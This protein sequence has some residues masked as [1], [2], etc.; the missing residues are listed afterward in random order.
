M[1][2]KSHFEMETTNKVSRLYGTEKL[3][4]PRHSHSPVARNSLR[5]RL[6]L[7]EIQHER[8]LKGSSARYIQI[9][10]SMPSTTFKSSSRYLASMLWKT[11]SHVWKVFRWVPPDEKS[12]HGE[13]KDG[14]EYEESISIRLANLI[15]FLVYL[16]PF[17]CA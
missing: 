8:K 12:N 17:M 15:M 4:K 13:H 3:P 2:R 10:L 7:Q 5:V 6:P 9:Y 16:R 1:I 11:E 14:V